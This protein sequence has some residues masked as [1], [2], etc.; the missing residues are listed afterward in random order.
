LTLE[1][2]C[3]EGSDEVDIFSQFVDILAVGSCDFD[4]GTYVIGPIDE[5]LIPTTFAI[6]EFDKLNF[7]EL[8]RYEFQFKSKA[9]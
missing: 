7:L 3:Q 2:A 9:Q 4:I 6:I 1:G 5:V 8:W